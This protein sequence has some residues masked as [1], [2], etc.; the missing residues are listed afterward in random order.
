MVLTFLC[1]ISCVH[2]YWDHFSP[3]LR[4]NVKFAH[5]LHEVHWVLV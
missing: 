3:V 4:E 2:V 1:V 5:F